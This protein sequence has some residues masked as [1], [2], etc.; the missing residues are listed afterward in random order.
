LRDALPVMLISLTSFVL[1]TGSDLWILGAFRAKEEVAV[2]GAAAQLVTFIAMPLVMTNLVLPSII[3]EMNA[4]GQRER[5]ERTVRAFSTLAGIP[6]LLVLIAFMLV[7]G[8]VMGV[9]YGEG[10]QSG[11]AV[12]VLLSLGKLVAVWSGSC[13]AVLQF[14][15]HQMAMLRVSLLTSPL[16]IVGALLVVGDYGPEGVASMTAVT[17]VVQNV[18]MVLVAKRKTGIWTHVS[19]SLS[20]FRKGPPKKE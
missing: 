6:S 17:A 7:G 5:L 3:A 8:S 9:V 10:Y 18:I 15:G 1:L 2:Y 11:R 19:L 13:G 12:L 20:P 4:R 14:T 16:F